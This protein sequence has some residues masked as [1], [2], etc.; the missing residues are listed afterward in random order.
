VTELHHR[1]SPVVF[2]WTSE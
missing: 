2:A 1:R